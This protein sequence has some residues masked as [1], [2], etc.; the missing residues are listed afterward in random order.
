MT[1][2]QTDDPLR[3]SRVQLWLRH[4][5]LPIALHML[6]CLGLYQS[7]LSQ[8]EM[9]RLRID[10]P[11]HLIDA[12]VKAAHLYGPWGVVRAYFRGES[13]E[14]LYLEYARLLLQ[15]EVDL[16]FVANRQ[17]DPRMLTSLP[18]RAWPYRDVRVEYPPLSFLAFA[19]PALIS[20]A[21]TAYRSG[22]IA[23]ML[24]LHLCNLWLAF[25]LLAPAADPVQRAR[26]GARV[27]YASLLFCAALG[28]LVVTRMDH[29]AVTWTLLSLLALKRAEHTRGRA[30]LV[31]AGACGAC[32]MLGAMTKLVPGFALLA[33]ILVWLRS[34]APDRQRCIVVSLGAAAVC[35]LAINLPLFAWVGDRY[36]DTFRY[37]GR[38]G[39]QIESVY[40]GLLMLLRPLGLDLQV[41]ESY[42]STNLATSVTS[43]VKLLSPCAFALGAG[44]VAFRRRF[45]NDAAGATWLCCTW[46]LIFMLSNRVFSPQYLIWVAAPVCVLATLGPRELRLA[47]LFLAAV[48]ISQLIFPRGY[49]LLKTFHPLGVAL[50]N[51]RNLLLLAFTVALVRSFAQRRVD[52]PNRFQGP[53]SARRG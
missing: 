5:A 30:R 47:A 52:I 6:L 51:L 21:Y 12:Y 4:A 50:L 10:G 40:A 48:L 32:A 2:R 19:P 14:R 49:P 13:D 3:S 25:Q 26:R 35:A 39:I 37:H 20:T 31:S 44:Y 43:I 53:G 29:L 17:N 23:Y 34:A 9:V 11:S 27:L 45:T 8:T 33:A 46:L 42:G 22:F 28:S 16:A 1:V 24:A 15:G 41:E 38:R 36:L 18:E 7:G